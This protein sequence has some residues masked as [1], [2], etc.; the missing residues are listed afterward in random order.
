MRKRTTARN[1][2]YEPTPQE[3]RSACEEFQRLW[4]NKERLRRAGESEGAQWTPPVISYRELADD[5][6]EQA[7]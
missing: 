5:G 2:P 3:I 6:I 4:S 1:E 7:A